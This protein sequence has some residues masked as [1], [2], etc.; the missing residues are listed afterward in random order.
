MA[1]SARRSRETVSSRRI[2]QTSVG[3]ARLLRSSPTIRHHAR[4]CTHALTRAWLR[5]R[6]RPGPPAPQ[7]GTTVVI[8]PH[9]DDAELGCGGL[10]ATRVALGRPVAVVC[11]TDGSGSHPDHPSLRPAELAVRRRAEALSAG[12]QLGLAAT[13]VT[14]LNALDGSLSR[15]S[16]PEHAG[17]VAR[18]ANVLAAVSVAE[19]FTPCARDGS[20]EHEAVFALVREAITHQS[21]RP[22]VYE[23]PVWSWWNPLLLWPRAISAPRVWRL[24]RA[25]FAADKRRAIHEHRSQIEPIAPWSQAVLHPEF[26]A[27]FESSDEYYFQQ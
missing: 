7:T 23:Y 17:L 16:T 20:C 5:T 19:L 9:P 13:A 3:L 10:I 26:V 24:S 25:M 2:H 27:L 12:G 15:L 4:R 21:F 8:A 11:I 1:D 22:R 6:S 14:F 18:L